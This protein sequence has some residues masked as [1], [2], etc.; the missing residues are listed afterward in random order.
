MMGEEERL[1]RWVEEFASFSP[2]N[3]ESD[4]ASFPSTFTVTGNNPD[5]IIDRCENLIKK[6]DS[7]LTVLEPPAIDRLEDHGFIGCAMLVRA[8][9]ELTSQSL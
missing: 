6:L 2:A 9:Q 3:L 7:N 8:H 5:A 4:L 1:M